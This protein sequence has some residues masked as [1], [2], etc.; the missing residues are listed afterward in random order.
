M[1]TNYLLIHTSYKSLAESI[2]QLTEEYAAKKVTE[3]E[4]DQMVLAWDSNCPNLLY[5]GTDRQSLA[6]SLLRYTG[7]RRGALIMA[8]LKRAKK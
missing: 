1:L 3:E 7:K 8:A 2:T 5:D 6:V 4:L